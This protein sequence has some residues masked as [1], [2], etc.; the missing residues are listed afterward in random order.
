MEI[1]N[2]FIFNGKAITKT[3]LEKHLS[4]SVLKEYV[5]AEELFNYFW[6]LGIDSGTK[7]YYQGNIDELIEYENKIVQAIDILLSFYNGKAK[8]SGVT[9]DEGID[10]YWHI[11]SEQLL[12]DLLSNLREE[13]FQKELANQFDVEVRLALSNTPQSY[14]LSRK[15]DGPISEALLGSTKEGIKG[16]IKELKSI[17]EK[18]TEHAV[19]EFLYYLNDKGIQFTNEID[20]A[21]YD[22]MDFFGFISS[23]VKRRHDVQVTS[24]DPFSN[25]ISSFRKKKWNR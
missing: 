5:P 17:K 23:D 1:L 10:D 7:K 14:K 9:I 18:R 22:I 6:Q 13:D 4:N 24:I 25:Y 11:Y 16:V 19:R 8:C 21:I 3:D 20:R 2:T 15:K 12:I